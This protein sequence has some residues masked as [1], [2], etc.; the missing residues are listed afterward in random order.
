MGKLLNKD[1]CRSV[2]NNYVT[3]TTG[4]QIGQ[5]LQLGNFSQVGHKSY[6]ISDNG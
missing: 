5:F 6:A 4:P 2:S 1:L 3:H